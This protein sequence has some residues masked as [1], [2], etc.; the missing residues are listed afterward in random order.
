MYQAPTDGIYS[1]AGFETQQVTQPSWWERAFD[2]VEDAIDRA[3]PLPGDQALPGTTAGTGTSGT[4][5]QGLVVNQTL[6]WLGLG[7][8][9]GALLL[10]YSGK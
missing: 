5:T 4:N 1:S 7:L 8:L 3:L 9:A 6:L 10:K 2:I